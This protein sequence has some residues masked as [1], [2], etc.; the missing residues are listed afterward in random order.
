MGNKISVVIPHFPFS[1][2]INET[3]KRCADSLFGY[4]ELVLVVNEGIGFAKAVNQGLRLAKGDYIM[5]VNNDIEWVQGD[6][7]ELC[8]PGV[9]TSPRVNGDSQGFWGCFFVVPREVYELIGGLDEQF[10]TGFYE[11]DDYIKRL[12]QAG[13]E[14]RS[15]PCDIQSKG[16]QTM[17][18]FDIP[19]LMRVNKDKFEKK[20]NH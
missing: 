19:E 7:K 4:D 10:G 13:I 1:N 17:S 18:Q 16:S 2:E 6:L 15:I 11:D 8:V 3:L 14:M 9:V 12:E 5:V 20:W